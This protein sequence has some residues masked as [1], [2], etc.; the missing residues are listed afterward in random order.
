MASVKT[1]I[2][3]IEYYQKDK[4]FGWTNTCHDRVLAS[5]EEKALE[6]FK[7]RHPDVKSYFVSNTHYADY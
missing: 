4:H 5:S 6:K 7:K 1:A 2:Y 3:V